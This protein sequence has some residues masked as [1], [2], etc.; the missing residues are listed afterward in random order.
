MFINSLPTVAQIPA[1]T[2]AFARK[3]CKPKSPVKREFLPTAQKLGFLQIG[4]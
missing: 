3:F 1:K 4:F 2:G